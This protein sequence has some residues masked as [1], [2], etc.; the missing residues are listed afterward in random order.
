MG[1]LVAVEIASVQT[2]VGV[3]DAGH[4]AES[5]ANIQTRVD[6]KDP[7]ELSEPS[8][9]DVCRFEKLE[10]E[11]FDL[12]EIL[13]RKELEERVGNL[14]AR[15]TADIQDQVEGIGIGVSAAVDMANI[16]H[17]THMSVGI[18]RDVQWNPSRLLGALSDTF[19]NAKQV[20]LRNRS[21]LGAKGEYELGWR[22]LL[23]P[24][25]DD[26]LFITVGGNIG[27]GIIAHGRILQGVKGLAGECGHLIVDPNSP[28]ICE[29]CH[30]PG[31][32]SKLASGRALVNYVVDHKD[33][34][35]CPGMDEIT[36]EATSDQG[37]SPK[38]D[39][40]YRTQTDYKGQSYEINARSVLAAVP[41]GSLLASNA[42]DEMSTALGKF[43]SQLAY[44]L[45]PSIVVLGGVASSLPGLEG[46]I[47]PKVS[48]REY[49]VG[50]HRLKT[51][52]LE[53][54]ATLYGAALSVLDKNKIKTT[55][56]S[57][58]P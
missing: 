35:A 17:F 19:K 15:T 36:R 47:D 18:L 29:I 45:D 25:A 30:Q 43:I 55:Q 1:K 57:P 12:G 39:V 10:G 46:I 3:I 13:R 16:C 52:A 53:D 5:C 24:N 11:R 8:A 38:V 32:A 42:V 4:L 31:C 49:A 40:G 56:T 27:V 9:Q 2:R 50:Q 6:G 14:I 22:P 58:N 28:V 48:L 54:N 41:S 23:V 44:V 21:N 33:D 20:K 34:A 26:L 7:D 37:G 51:S